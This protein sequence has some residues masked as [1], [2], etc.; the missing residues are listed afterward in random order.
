MGKVFR[1]S[2]FLIKL[3]T[4]YIVAFVI[5]LFKPSMR[6]IWL[7]SERGDDARDNG[8]FFYKYMVEKHP[9]KRFYY[10][11]KKSSVDAE[12]IREQDLIA[13]NSFRHF[14]Y[15]ALC[16]VRIS[17]HAL[18]GDVPYIDY[19]RK[20]GFDKRTKK[21]VIFL[22]HGI[23]KDFLPALC[24]PNIRP[25][26]FVCGAEPEWRYIH[27]N[28]NYPEGIVQ[29]TGL[30]RYDSLNEFKT[31]NQILVMPTFRRYLQGLSAEN[32]LRE[33]Y[34]TK[35]Q[36]LLNSSQVIE[37]LEKNGLDLIFYPHYEMQKYVD[38]FE[39]RSD[40]VKIADFD[41]YDVQTLL[42]ESKLMITDFSSVF[43]D[44]SYMR[45]PVIFYQFDRERYIK[46]HYDFTKGYFD[47]DVTAPGKAVF[48][49]NSLVKEFAKIL[50]NDFKVEKEYTDRRDK[51]FTKSD[52]HNCD[53]IYEAIIGLIN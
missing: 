46:G 16:K 1:V 37:L 34:Y 4:A 11:I 23:I 8:Y 44:F 14:I 40:K 20:F 13:F 10:V 42:K 5:K 3:F 26:L 48:D 53:R 47:Y 30:A 41:H 24:Y 17:S 31:K 18:G 27:D 6:G 21:K 38:L 49:E 36:S 15:F 29:Y 25:D 28:F 35:W 9:E 52:R 43:F 12:K 19:Y 39:S 45:K 33:E 32:F 2:A 7:I 22:Q 50:D 51:F